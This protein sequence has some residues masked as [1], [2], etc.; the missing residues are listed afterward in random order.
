M[1]KHLFGGN[2]SICFSDTSVRKVLCRPEE[3]FVVKLNKQR[4]K[5]ATPTPTNKKRET[6][7][8]SLIRSFSLTQTTD[9]SLLQYGTLSHWE[10]PYTLPSIFNPTFQLTW[11]PPSYPLTEPYY[12]LTSLQSSGIELCQYPSLL[13]LEINS[14][15]QS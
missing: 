14:K 3:N 1:E 10:L 7:E 5:Q 15:E 9:L 8:Q 2:L 12:S 4:N 13:K 6:S 11:K